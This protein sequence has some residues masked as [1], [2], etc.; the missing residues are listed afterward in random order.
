VHVER[1][2]RG[3]GGVSEVK[4][5]EPKKKRS[6]LFKEALR[7]FAG[8]S[9]SMGLFAE[10][11]VRPSI[12]RLFRERDIE[13]NKVSA[14]T[15]SQ[16]NGEMMEVDVHGIGPTSVVLVEVKFKL[17]LD[18]VKAVLAKLQNFFKFFP[19]Y[20]GRFLYGAVAGTSIDAGADRYA[21][22][23]GL[24]VLAQSGDDI[25]I[26]NDLK[27]V[28]KTFPIPSVKKPKRRSFSNFR[29][30]PTHFDPQLPYGNTA[31]VV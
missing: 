9:K 23:K 24:F 14:R 4:D 17:E 20:R 19:E 31:R 8:L 27:F 10:S 5:K 6:Q 12:V 18:D 1:G 13:L 22:K 28:P 7:E 26:L 15:K 25:R 21:Y 29:R 3:D 30:V 16:W 2:R 11:T